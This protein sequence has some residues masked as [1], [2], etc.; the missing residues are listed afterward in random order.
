MSDAARIKRCHSSPRRL[1]SRVQRDYELVTREIV[2]RL[3]IA[4]LSRSSFDCQLAKSSVLALGSV[5]NI[6]V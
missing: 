2:E 3:A 4:K 5:P 1:T 6:A